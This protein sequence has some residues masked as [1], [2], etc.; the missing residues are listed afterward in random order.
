MGVPVTHSALADGLLS[1][2]LQDLSWPQI[3]INM[4]HTLSAVSETHQFVSAQLLLLASMEASALETV[5]RELDT[6]QQEK[7]A[8]LVEAVEAVLVAA[9]IVVV[10]SFFLN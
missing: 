1:H 6:E 5:R 4:Q 8:V 2:S 10:F 9:V 3:V 7:V